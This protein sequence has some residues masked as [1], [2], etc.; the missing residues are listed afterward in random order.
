MKQLF[1]STK[2]LSIRW[3]VSIHTL[4][5]WRSMNKGPRY[6]KISGRASYKIEDIEEFEKKAEYTG[7]IKKTNKSEND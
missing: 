6:S 2:E 7:R 4:K 3:G 1:L 5:Q